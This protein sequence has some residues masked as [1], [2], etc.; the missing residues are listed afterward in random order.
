MT[1]RDLQPIPWPTLESRVVDGDTVAIATESQIDTLIAIKKNERRLALWAIERDSTA[2]VYAYEVLD[3]RQSCQG[4]DWKMIGLAI[5]TGAV[6]GFWI[7][8]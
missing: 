3:L 2:T 4:M 6:A 7:A 5:M 8:R 1:I